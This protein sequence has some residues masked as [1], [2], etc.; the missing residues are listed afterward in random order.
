MFARADSE[1]RVKKGKNHGEFEGKI[2]HVEAA[3]G[4][5][6]GVRVRVLRAGGRGGTR[7]RAGRDG[8]DGHGGR[9]GCSGPA[10]LL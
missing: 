8:R 3:A 9:T 10:H 2:P 4:S 1:I 5:P 6:D 7:N